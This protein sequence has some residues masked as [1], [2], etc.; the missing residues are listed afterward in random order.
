M[1][2]IQDLFAAQIAANKLANRCI[3]C[4]YSGPFGATDSGAMSASD[5]GANGATP[6]HGIR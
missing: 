2:R 1:Q 6:N 3:L 5:S 4:D